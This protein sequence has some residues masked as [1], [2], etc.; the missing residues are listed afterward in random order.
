MK[1]LSC[2]SVI[3]KCEG[4][5]GLCDIRVFSSKPV[6]GVMAIASGGAIAVTVGLVRVLVGVMI[7]LLHQGVVDLVP[8][9]LRA[10]G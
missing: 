3:L 4:K 1:E 2:G 6:P 9:V 7:V 8:A 10:G 5:R